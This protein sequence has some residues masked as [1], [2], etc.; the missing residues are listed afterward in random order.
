MKRNVEK[1]KN[2][3]TLKDNDG[4]GERRVGGDWWNH[5]LN[6]RPADLPELQGGRKG[7]VHQGVRRNLKHCLQKPSFKGA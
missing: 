5:S 1:F 3:D 7:E 6:F 2:K 4:F